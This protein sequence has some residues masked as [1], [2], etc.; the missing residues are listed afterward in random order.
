MVGE[1]DELR[2]LIEQAET[3]IGDLRGVLDQ[4]PPTDVMRQFAIAISNRPT[5]DVM[6]EFAKANSNRPT[7]DVMLEF[8]KAVRDAKEM[9]YGQGR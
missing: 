2:D 3:A 1:A 6:V 4:M 7:A 9:G 8:A 5:A